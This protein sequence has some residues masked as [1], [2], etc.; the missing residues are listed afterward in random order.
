MSLGFDSVFG[1]ES[2][3]ETELILTHP[4]SAACVEQMPFASWIN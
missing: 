1:L 2:R 4:P 3:S